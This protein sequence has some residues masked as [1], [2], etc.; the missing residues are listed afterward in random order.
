MISSSGSEPTTEVIVDRVV[1]SASSQ[2][3]K[4]EPGSAAH[5]LRNLHSE[6]AP[7]RAALEPSGSSSLLVGLGA[8]D[9]RIRLLGA[10]ARNHP[11]MA[12]LDGTYGDELKRFEQSLAAQ[13]RVDTLGITVSASLIAR[14]NGYF[15]NPQDRCVNT[16][17]RYE[18]MVCLGQTVG[19]QI[20][21]ARAQSIEPFTASRPPL[22]QGTFEWTCR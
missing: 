15:T 6:V 18:L 7:L 11:D 3:E 4:A 2:T 16:A 21:E 14:A 17:H 22:T 13:A 20:A 10:A 9:E 12:E 19:A 8:D 1:I 5:M